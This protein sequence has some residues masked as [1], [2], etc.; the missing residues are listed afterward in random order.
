MT[1]AIPGEEKRP[2]L[3]VVRNARVRAVADDEGPGRTK[4]TVI[5]ALALFLGFALLAYF[6]P[7]IMLWLV[8]ISPWAAATLVAVFLLLP[9]V[10]FGLRGRYQRRKDR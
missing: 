4:K 5:A 1:A 7:P 2:K 10:V 6:L 9:F 8:E 3:A